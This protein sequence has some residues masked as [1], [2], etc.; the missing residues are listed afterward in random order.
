MISICYILKKS[1]FIF[2]FDKIMISMYFKSIMKRISYHLPEQTIATLRTLSDLT[3][4]AV[5]EIIRRSIDSY[6]TQQNI[7]IY[8]NLKKDK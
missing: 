7:P 8:E 3:G 6:L 1:L 2:L 4:I 5:A